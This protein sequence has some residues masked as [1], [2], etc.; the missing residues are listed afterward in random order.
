MGRV[1]NQHPAVR[2]DLAK[3]HSYI[4]ADNP[5][6]ADR[7][8]DAIKGVFQALTQFSQTGRPYKRSAIKNLRGMQ[9]PKYRNYLV[10]YTDSPNTV[11]VLYV[12]HGARDLPEIL[13]QDNRN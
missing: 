10:F 8:I 2:E 9:V 11:R 7:V 3:I 12:L 5:L 6:A 13:Q 4:A 1:L